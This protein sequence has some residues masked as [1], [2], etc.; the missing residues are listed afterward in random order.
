MRVFVPSNINGDHDTLV[1][2]APLQDPIFLQCNCEMKLLSR[3]Q[4]NGKKKV[5]TTNRHQNYGVPTSSS[6][7]IATL[8]SESSPVTIF[9]YDSN[10]A[11]V[12]CFKAPARRVGFFA[13]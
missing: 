6:E 5:T 10:A 1:I 7:V 4:Y 3:S 13:N 8:A 9:A 11:M 12:D 2:R